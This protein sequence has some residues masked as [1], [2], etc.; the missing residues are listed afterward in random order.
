MLCAECFATAR[1]PVD[2]EEH[3]QEH[4][5]GCLTYRYYE[6]AN[7]P[8]EAGQVCRECGAASYPRRSSSGL[9]PDE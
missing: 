7:V 5:I 2:R 1:E 4:V 6:H 9:D 3:P 8:V